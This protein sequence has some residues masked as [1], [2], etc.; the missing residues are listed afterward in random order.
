[1]PIHYACQQG[2]TA[3]VELLL[4]YDPD[5]ICQNSPIGVLHLAVICNHT[6]T[7]Q[8]LLDL[9]FD[10]N[11]VDGQ[12]YTALDYAAIFGHIGVAK[13]LLS[14]G[15]AVGDNLHKAAEQG[16]ADFVDLLINGGA[17]VDIL[18]KRK[19]TALDLAIDTGDLQ[20]IEVLFSHGAGTTRA[21]PYNRLGV[22]HT[23]TRVAD[24]MLVT[25]LVTRAGAPINGMDEEGRTALD[26]AVLSRNF[27]V[28]EVLRQLGARAACTDPKGHRVQST[29]RGFI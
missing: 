13:I 23:A 12:G 17:N 8:L 26:Y 11:S 14:S 19:L 27:G 16:R 9:G 7:T 3:I 25:A 6:Y 22:F 24:P 18:D 29:S 28:V 15:A 5:R 2:R 20:C 10:V 4:L 21:W 1:M